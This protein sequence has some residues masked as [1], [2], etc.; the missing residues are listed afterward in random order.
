VTDTGKLDGTGTSARSL[1]VI[2]VP[3]VLTAYNTAPIVLEAAVGDIVKISVD[4][5]DPNG[6]HSPTNIRLVL[7]DDATAKTN[8]CTD[9]NNDCY[10]INLGTINPASPP[11]NCTTNPGGTG[12]TRSTPTAAGTKTAAGIDPYLTVSCNETVHFNANY[13][14]AWNVNATV[15]DS[16]SEVTLFADSSDFASNA[17]L[18]IGISS[19]TPS[20]A[21]GT[22]A[23]GTDS[24]YKVIK[25][26]NQGNQILDYGLTGTLM[27][28]DSPTCVGDTI[29]RAQQHWEHGAATFV[30]STGNALLETVTAGGA[31]VNGC[32][33]SNAA[34][35]AVY[36]VATEDVSTSW[37]IHI[38]ANAKSGSYAGENTWTVATSTTCTAP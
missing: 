2:D 16:S 9:D 21:Y 11:A 19:T 4:L 32:V 33:D 13:S 35:R 12:E 20:I 37:I 24:V 23:L 31:G 34:V 7:W 8:Q 17:L 14:A 18:A 38:P 25:A 27:C 36:N 5:S 6:D 30:W 26:E 1:A 10:I 28:T 3:S 29:A 15:T 22:V